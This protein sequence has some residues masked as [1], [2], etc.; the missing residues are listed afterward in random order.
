MSAPA[1]NSMLGIF[2]AFAGKCSG[3]LARLISVV[4]LSENGGERKESFIE[5]IV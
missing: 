2:A 4:S 5:K 3:G 1:L